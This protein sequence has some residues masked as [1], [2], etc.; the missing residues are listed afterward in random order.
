MHTKTI[1]NLFA[2]IVFSAIAASPCL[3]ADSGDAAL[4][5]LEAKWTKAM[6]A[7]DTATLDTIVAS[8]WMGQNPSGKMTTKAQ[9]VAD[10]TSGKNKITAMTNRDVHARVLGD[11]AVVQGADDETSSYD[12]KD[13]SGAYTWTDVFQK[14]GGHWM[15]IAS[16]NT[17]VA[18]H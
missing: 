2:V 11:V 16:Q 13:T 5:A 14:R 3:A 17:P 12:G 7:K 8:D 9:M 15:A 18:T 10:M 6:L 1:P 4:I